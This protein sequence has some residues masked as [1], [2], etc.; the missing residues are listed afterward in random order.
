MGQ[1]SLDPLRR[2]HALRLPLL[3]KQS[4]GEVHSFLELADPLLQLLDRFRQVRVFIF[5]FRPTAFNPISVCAQYRR[6]GFPERS[7]DDEYPYADGP[8][9]VA[10]AA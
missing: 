2:S 7:A 10:H 9:E 8:A 4:L 3:G 6:Q 1:A 5:T